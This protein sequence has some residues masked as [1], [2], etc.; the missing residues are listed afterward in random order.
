ME[1]FTDGIS[2]QIVLVFQEQEWPNIHKAKELL[3]KSS[4][5]YFFTFAY[6]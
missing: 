3:H 4:L 5:C 1:I 6:A 2:F